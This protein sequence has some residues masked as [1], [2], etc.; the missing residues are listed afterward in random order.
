MFERA[1]RPS[2]DPQMFDAPMFLEAAMRMMQR[3]DVATY[4]HL[5]SVG[6]LSSR[7]A[8]AL[9]LRPRE[10]DAVRWAG[11]LHD[12]GKIGISRLILN[13]PRPLTQ[14]EW[15]L[16]KLHPENGAAYARKNGEVGLADVIGAHHE[17]LDGGGYPWG[18]SGTRIPIGARII[19]VADTFDVLTSGRPYRE[20][21]TPDEAIGLILECSGTQFDPDVVDAI[22]QEHACGILVPRRD[23]A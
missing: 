6:A 19:A 17:R 13:A 7:L 22:V 11:L 3:Y 18:L 2:D 20:A 8:I 12:F 23:I 9:D 21:L 1:P 14:T 16:I 15:Q 4:E 5:L 10:R